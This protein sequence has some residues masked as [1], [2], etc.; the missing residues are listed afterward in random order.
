MTLDIYRLKSEE[1]DRDFAACEWRLGTR[2]D[3]GDS[4]SGGGEA[5]LDVKQLEREE[6]VLD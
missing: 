6:D 5:M 4:G 3:L 1:D 2:D